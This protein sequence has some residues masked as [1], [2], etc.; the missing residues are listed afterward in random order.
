MYNLHMVAKTMSLIIEYLS[1]MH[2]ASAVE[3]SR[4]LGMTKGNIQYHV[5]ILLREEKIEVVDHY[6]RPSKRGRPELLYRLSAANRPNNLAVLASALLDLQIDLNASQTQPAG[7][8]WLQQLADKMSG[9]VN[10][11]PSFVQRLNAAVT[12]LIENN[13]QARWEVRQAGPCIFLRNCPYASILN[14]HPELCEM[15]A[16]LVRNLTGNQVELR[17]IMDLRDA[18]SSC[19]LL[20]KP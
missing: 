8:P 6:E 12:H 20:I 15:D 19:V 17:E 13:Y 4:A 2:T 16:A 14:E 10:T 18:D 7:R 9:P 11:S 3:L 5:K 1:R